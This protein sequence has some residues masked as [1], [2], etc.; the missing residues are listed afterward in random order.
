MSDELESVLRKSLD[1]V[2]RHKRRLYGAIIAGTIFFVWT[3]SQLVDAN[4]AGD[5]GR[6]VM[7]SVVVVGCWTSSLA[8]VIVLQLTVMTKRILRAIEIASKE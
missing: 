3:F 6:M 5:M 8:F 1:A 4:R 2:D 7:L